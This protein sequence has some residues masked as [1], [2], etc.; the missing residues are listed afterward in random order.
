LEF[1][2]E[3]GQLGLVVGADAVV[4]E[5]SVNSTMALIFV[6]SYPSTSS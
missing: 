4:V 1:L 5:P 6:A 3:P 2:D